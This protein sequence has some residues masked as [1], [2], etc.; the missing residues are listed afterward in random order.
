MIGLSAAACSALG[1]R[2]GL[3]VAWPVAALVAINVAT[4]ALYAYDKAVAGSSAGR[5]PEA[6]LHAA[7][8]CGGSPAALIA[9][10]ALRHKTAKR[11]FQITFWTIVVIQGAA[12]A[13]YATR[14]R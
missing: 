8:L 14:L 4:F 7:A 3:G 12:A 2:L 6:V 1:L 9:Q 13:W 5:V 10:Q 11:P